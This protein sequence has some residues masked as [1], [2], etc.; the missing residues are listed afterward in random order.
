MTS[1]S[2]FQRY[3]Q[4]ENHL[5]NNTLLMLRYLSHTSTQKFEEL[6]YELFEVERSIGPVFQQQVR[7]Q[8]N[9]VYDGVISQQPFSFIIETK[10]HSGFN[11]DQI[12]RYIDGIATAKNNPGYSLNGEI[13]LIGLTKKE[14]IEQDKHDLIRYASDKGLHFI[15]ITFE[16][17]LSALERICT[18]E[19]PSL[20]PVYQD[21]ANYLENEEMLNKDILKGFPCNHTM[22]F[23]LRHHIYTVSSTTPLHLNARYIGFYQHKCIEYIAEIE[24]IV[25]GIYEF[26]SET[27]EVL[28]QIKGNFDDAGKDRVIALNND[29][30]T[31]VG[32]SVRYYL[33]G[34]PVQTEFRKHSMYGLQRSKNF[35][36]SDFLCNY[37]DGKTSIKD[38][39]EGLRKVTW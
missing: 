22:D 23:N 25:E 34:T 15:S 9:H 7:E 20:D 3:S 12:K 10:H 14:I 36:L 39:A 11:L 26:E 37:V 6:L 1:I 29:N 13:A 38:T 2:Y 28:R 24:T 21:Y 35:V 17:L 16:E 30:S 18:S 31:L 27:F 19:F 4:R 5:T 33:L 8:N 32:K